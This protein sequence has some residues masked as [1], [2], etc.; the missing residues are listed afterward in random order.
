MRWHNGYEKKA[1]RII[2]KHL[3]ESTLKIPFERSNQFNIVVFL[4]MYVDRKVFE[5][6]YLEIYKEIGFQHG[7]RIGKQINKQIGQKDFSFGSFSDVWLAEVQKFLLG[8]GGNKIV[9]VR[10]NY[11]KF[12]MELITSEY[13][14]GKTTLEISE[15][16]TKYLRSRNFYRW[17][18]MRIA[19]TETTTAANY[20]AVTASTVSGVVMEKVWISAQDA[21]TR[22]PPE[23]IYDH[24]DM[25]GKSVL[26]NEP[27]DVS[28]E[29]MQYPGDQK[30]GSAGNVINCRCTVAQRVKRDENGDIVRVNAQG[31]QMF[32]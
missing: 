15:V 22:R 13:S 7:Q 18:A 16:I 5:E 21:R 12:L 1:F 6:M 24:Y 27:F 19:R 4:E 3:K 23:S 9:T 26:L 20:A 10:Q 32:V 29:A 28:G 11:I 8:Q 25:N 14:E 30:N 31:Q 17:Q 2:R